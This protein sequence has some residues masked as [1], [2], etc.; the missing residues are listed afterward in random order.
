MAID[1]NG[2]FAR[3]LLDLNYPRFPSELFVLGAPK[4]K[5]V[6]KALRKLKVLTWNEVFQDHSLKWEELKSLPDDC[7]HGLANGVTALHRTGPRAVRG[8]KWNLVGV[9]PRYVFLSA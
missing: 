6:F 4:I 2:N 3:V 9:R 8:S 5:E 7:G 1:V